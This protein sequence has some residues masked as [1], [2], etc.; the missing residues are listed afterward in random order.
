M[1][2]INSKDGCNADPST[3]LYG[4]KYSATRN[5]IQIQRASFNKDTKKTLICQLT[6]S[7]DS[8]LQP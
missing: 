3:G 4:N 1:L 8:E 2:T 7:F 6:V 5:Q